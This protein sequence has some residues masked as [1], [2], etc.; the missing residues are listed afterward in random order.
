MEES[1][2]HTYLQDRTKNRPIKLPTNFVDVNTM[3]IDG[4]IDSGCND[5]TPIGQQIDS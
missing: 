5:G 4:K 1:A 2:R 3:Q